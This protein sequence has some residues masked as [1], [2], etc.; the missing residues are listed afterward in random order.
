MEGNDK[1]ESL[2]AE[3]LRNNEKAMAMAKEMGIDTGRRSSQTGGEVMSAA[4]EAAQRPPRPATTE[5]QVDLLD[6]VICRHPAAER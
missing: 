2:L 1:L 4:K 5:T 3:V 6:Q